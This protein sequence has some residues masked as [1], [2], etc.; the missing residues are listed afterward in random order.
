VKLGPANTRLVD[1]DHESGPTA[2]QRYVA[3]PIWS[4]A[5]VVTPHWWRSPG[6]MTA[7]KRKCSNLHILQRI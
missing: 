7:R 2:S 5:E 6:I 4:R 1:W 3:R